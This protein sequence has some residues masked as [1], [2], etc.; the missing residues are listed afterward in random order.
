MGRVLWSKEHFDEQKLSIA[1]L[2]QTFPDRL[3]MIAYSPSDNFHFM[4]EYAAGDQLVSRLRPAQKQ[5]RI[6]NSHAGLRRRSMSPRIRLAPVSQW[7]AGN[8]MHR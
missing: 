7:R 2:S 5:S 8:R 3:T 1:A 4:I 6:G